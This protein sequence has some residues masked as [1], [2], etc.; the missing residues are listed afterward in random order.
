M[1]PSGKEDV[2][3]S[4][5]LSL[6]EKRR[7]MRFLMFAGD[8]FESRNELRDR[9]QSPFFSFLREVFSLDEKSAR[10]I[11]YALAFCN[12]PSGKDSSALARDVA[13]LSPV[14]GHRSDASCASTPAPLSSFYWAIRAFSFSRWTLRRS[15]GAGTRFLQDVSRRRRHLHLG[16]RGCLNHN[17][18]QRST[19]RQW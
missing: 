1:V 13:P 18:R 19:D 8:D 17:D 12:S 7:L 4:K 3:R 2:F 9:E 16:S 14:F 15:R 5:E 11:T 10:A 6:V